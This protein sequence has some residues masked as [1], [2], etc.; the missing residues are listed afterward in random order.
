MKEINQRFIRNFCVLSHID[1]GKSTLADRFLEITNTISPRKIQPQYLDRMPL[2]R[3]RGITIKMQP[4]R[5]LYSINQV[6]YILN[7][8]DT[9]GH[10]DF[11]YE[12]SRSLAAVE[13]AI[14]LVDATKGIQAQTIANL[15]MAQ[16]ENLIIIPAVNKIDIA[17]PE[18]IKEA[19][20]ELA[21]LLGKEERNTYPT[22]LKN[23]EIHLVSAKTGENVEK[24]LLEGMEK[25]PAPEGKPNQPL[26]ALIFDSKYDFY[27]GVI[28][29]VKI[30]DG[31]IKQGD[32]IYLMKSKVRAEAVEIG[33]FKPDL[34][35]CDKLET[36]EIGYIATGLK[37]I[38]N[39]RVGDTITNLEIGNRKLKIQSL[40]G[41]QNVQ[42]MVFTSFYPVD[43]DDYD[44]LKDGLGK[45][46][47]NDASLSFDPESSK[48]LGRGFRCGFLGT[49]HLEIVSERLK[50]DYN[51]DLIITSPSLAYKI[52]KTVK[53]SSSDE[54]NKNNLIE[55]IYNAV[56]LPSAD[57]IKEIQQPWV[58][59]EI[60]LP[61]DYLGSVMKL[62]ETLSSKYKN[63]EYLGEN[64]LIIKFEIPFREIVTGFYNKLKS[65]TS[66]YGSMNYR[67][68]E[69]RKG[70]LVKLDIL[71]AKEKIDAFSRIV[72][73]E[74]AY[75]EGKR[76]VNLLKE[77]I[78]SQQFAVPIQAVVEGKIIVRETKKSFRK[79]V[80]AP[81][82]GGDYTRKKKL[83]EKQKKGKKKL[84]KFGRV[85]L[86]SEVFLKVLKET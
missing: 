34:T 39:C 76:L 16:K 71:L 67:F 78:P 23:N 4:V 30:V 61:N 12:V 51:L 26:R 17:S 70:D 55:F 83:L 21:G 38:E 62:L 52:I 45:L 20:K 73:K 50:R 81:L 35:P 33:Y 69:Y 84:A 29:Y 74:K 36:G 25:I 60:I 19:E 72:S 57:Q 24:L 42:P 32:R 85:N 82:Y 59:I 56:E 65:V 7:L 6:E 86:P 2:E 5:M 53:A 49:L 43:P 48:G 79:D 80:I 58:E 11:S 15:E 18:Q 14:L 3:E 54:P 75:G 46:K 28:A 68:I 64:K 31:E 13:G 27:K 37:N 41:Y 1:H 22:S 77:V 63:T 10:I 47:L 8:I 40:P 66:G 9:P 44:R